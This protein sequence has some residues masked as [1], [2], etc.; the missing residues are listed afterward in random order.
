V[1][2][3]LEV[4]E[5]RVKPD[6]TARFPFTVRAGHEILSINDFDVISDNAHFNPRWAHIIASRDGGAFR[7]HYILLVR[8]VDIRHRQYGT[9]PLRVRWAARGA[10]SHAEGACTL[11][12]TPCLRLGMR[13]TLKLR[14]TGTLSLSLENCGGV[15]LD[16]SIEIRHHG[17]SWSKGWEVELRAEDGPFEFTEQF[18]P[19]PGAGKGSREFDLNVSAEGISLIQMRL[20]PKA[21]FVPVKYIVPGAVLLAGLAAGTTFSVTKSSTVLATQSIAFASTPPPGP[22]AGDTYRLAVSGGGSG[23]PVAVTIDR[24]SA[25]ECSISGLTVT[26]NKAG[27]CVIDA[28]QAGNAKYQAAPQAQ[29]TVTVVNGSGSGSGLVTQ[30]ITFTS[31]PPSGAV[32]GDTYAVAASGGGSGNPVAVT[33]DRSSAAECSISGLTVTFN[34]AGT[35]VIDVNQAGNAKYQAA[36]QAQ[37]TARINKAALI[38]QAITFTSTPPPHASPGDTYAVTVSGG[39]SGNPVILTIDSSSAAV[40]SISGSTVTFDNTAACVIDANQAGNAK[41][42][43]APQAQQTA[44][45]SSPSLI[46]QAITFTS[47][48]PPHALRGSTYAVTVSGGASGNPVILTID[49]SSA[50][51][52]SISGSTVTFNNV[53]TCVIDANQ[54]GNAKYQPAP[55]AQQTVTVWFE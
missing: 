14:P 3:I 21:P 26:F 39:A 48:P 42:Q 28:N 7:T 32:P 23:N 2:I 10:A 4:N 6:E 34:K 50:A 31:T 5:C 51:V 17:S 1:N 46:A 30:A 35:C 9:Y 22:S 49:S 33:I 36:P 54:A 25:A 15:D 45:V 13:P 16:V 12:I 53:G 52:C 11:V 20:R 37:Q 29:Q 41:Y 44:K 43:A 47:T 40:C 8:P 19:P 38:P 24:S 27:T 55:Q 18:V